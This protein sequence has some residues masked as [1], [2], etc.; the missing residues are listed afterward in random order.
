M[1]LGITLI[2]EAVLKGPWTFPGEHPATHA[3]PVLDHG[4]G[5]LWR[6]DAGYGDGPR[7]P[8]TWQPY[9]PGPLVRAWQL[10]A[11]EATHRR[12]ADYARS[13][14][15]QEYDNAELV[16]QLGAVFT[17]MPGPLGQMARHV[18]N[19]D[20]VRNAM[21]CTKLT[22]R[23]MEKGGFPLALPDLIPERVAQWFRANLVVLP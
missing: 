16:A 7:R 4:D 12:M 13:L 21:I 8:A 19:T 20:F 1:S 23:V 2:T 22:S 3:F 14:T 5:Y 15:G 6:L 9:V 10:P 11:Y 18:A 17:R